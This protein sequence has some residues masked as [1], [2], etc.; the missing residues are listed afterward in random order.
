MMNKLILGLVFCSLC[1]GLSAAVWH[2]DSVQGNDDTAK[3]DDSGE[4]PFKTIQ[5]AINNAA[6]DDVIK[7]APGV[8]KTS[9]HEDATY[10]RSRIFIGKPLTIESTGN[11]DNT[12]I[13]GAWDESDAAH[14]LGVNA[15]R[16][17]CATTDC[18]I[19]GFT[20]LNGATQSGKDSN[21]TS[22]GGLLVPSGCSATANLEDCAVV[23][24]SATRGGGMRRSKAYRT[25]FSECY[26]SN[27]GAA[28]RESHHIFC[29]IK[30]CRGAHI[31]AYVRL[32]YHCTFVDNVLDTGYCVHSDNNNRF[33]VGNCLFVSGSA[34][35]SLSK[36]RLDGT[37]MHG[38]PSFAKDNEW[39]IDDTCQT[40]VW[41]GGV[42]S[43]LFGDVRP[44]AGGPLDGTGNEEMKSS[45]DSAY[46]EYDV[47]GNPVNW[48][49]GK[50]CPGAYQKV[51][52]PASGKMIF[53]N[54]T[55]RISV[56]GVSIGSLDAASNYTYAT[57]W[58]TQ[59]L[60][61]VAV[62]KP[63]FKI[64]RMDMY[65][66]GS[67]SSLMDARPPL[68]HDDEAWIT[69][70]PTGTDCLW[71][72]Y[73]TDK[74]YYVDDDA[75]FEGEA[76]GTETKPYRTIQDAVRNTSGVRVICVKEGVYASDTGDDPLNGMKNRVQLDN[77]GYVRL[78]GVDGAEKT[79]IVGAA[80]P[81]TK[82]DPVKLGCGPKAVRCITAVVN[83]VIQGFT[84]TGGHSDYGD[85][86]GDTSIKV[87]GGMGTA[88]SSGDPS[89]GTFFVDCIISNNVAYRGAMG[90]GGSY[91]RCFFANNHT[92]RN[93]GGLKAALAANCI[94]TANYSPGGALRDSGSY[95]YNCTLVESDPVGGVT[96]GRGYV[97]N[98]ICCGAHAPPDAVTGI[99]GTVIDGYGKTSGQDTL[100]ADPCFK[101]ADN[102]DFRIASVSPAVGFG[103]PFVANWWK[104][105]GSD[106][107]GNRYRFVNGKVISG[108]LQNPVA[109]VRLG[110]LGG[111]ESGVSKVGVVFLD[112]DVQEV[113]VVA[114]DADTRLFEGFSKNGEIIEGSN[115]SASYT[116]VSSEALQLPGDVINA[117]YLTNWYVNASAGNDSNRG[118][119]LSSAKKTLK[120]AFQHVVPGDVVHAAEGEYREGTMIH[121]V[122]VATKAGMTSAGITI[123]SRV[124][125]P[126]G[127]SL[128]ADGN[129]DKTI[130]FG[131][132]DPDT[133]SHVTKRGCG[134]KAVRCVMMETNTVIR[135]FTLR[136]GRTGYE[137]IEDDDYQGGGILASSSASDLMSLVENCTIKDC[138]S[139]RGGGSYNGYYRCCRFIGNTAVQNG[140]ASRQGTYI[141][142]YFAG[143]IGPNVITY[144]GEVK[145]CTFGLGNCNS[146]GSSTF[147]IGS[148]THSMSVT[149]TLFADGF[150][151]ESTRQ[152]KLYNCAY[153]SDITLD[154]NFTVADCVTASV[155]RLSMLDENGVPVPG[156]NPA[157]DMGVLSQ[158]TDCSLS[159]EYDAAGNQRVANGS[160]DIGCYEAD[161]K[162][163]YSATVGKRGAVTFTEAAASAHKGDTN[164]VFLPEGELSG[165]L[166]AIGG[167]Y[168]F[169][170]WITGGGRLLVSIG[171]DIVKEYTAGTSVLS[172]DM[173]AGVYPMSFK[174]IPSENDEGGA[175]IGAGGRIF[176]TTIVVR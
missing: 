107:N 143:N 14:G 4:T 145:Q 5:A 125:I 118:D 49:K 94:F 57:C 11:R 157:C 148:V 34:S 24:C 160:M 153:A 128:V 67:S 42:I 138:M 115:E 81:D 154:D 86:D 20:L 64:A 123:P 17:V 22:G 48:T 116:Y 41:G 74:K 112:E 79:F 156:E 2:V 111:P 103:D 161:W 31:V 23:R 68:N 109:S 133:A 127:V 129:R 151:A 136:G 93:D 6:D 72:P 44:Y 126:A 61:K 51:I 8:Y 150:I 121:T 102:G 113:T 98:S 175:F 30:K 78:I 75:V 82:D 3:L 108:A 149:G 140:A 66:N 91:L 92:I 7:V 117:V 165:T 43:P 65:V 144:P 9:L 147:A 37:V 71:S 163:V 32:L 69:A 13:E 173:L 176:G 122:N 104:Y 62:S 135:G 59:Y 131:D 168:E 38:N 120:A 110:V 158:W 60:M 45:I 55:A 166:N 170:V 47:E 76:D 52:T 56:D 87:Y 164:E 124:L 46:R 83:S 141:G 36:C 106:F 155:E 50:L 88:T 1:G 130:I 100:R 19:K 77:G 167:H 27:Y 70:P 40:N 63:T 137:N 35:F 25:I 146:N 10:G 139:Y 26:A 16:C 12:V 132:S 142:C 95:T 96:Y 101:D 134:P 174:Y 152:Y 159:A 99:K 15:I 54:S 162:G 80:D 39:T 90:Y 171:D 119:S 97:Y 84:L 73:Q 58:P 33:T 114:T 21:L 18:T 105:A 28:S 85:V 169:P 29:L 53:R 172:F 89:R